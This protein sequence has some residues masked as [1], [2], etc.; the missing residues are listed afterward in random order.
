VIGNFDISDDILLAGD[1]LAEKRP[2]AN[3]RR[4]C[5]ESAAEFSCRL[6]KRS[7]RQRARPASQRQRTVKSGDAS[8]GLFEHFLHGFGVQVMK[9]IAQRKTVLLAERDI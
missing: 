4:A 8:T 2:P 7:K 6:G 1:A 5:A 3:L 9:D